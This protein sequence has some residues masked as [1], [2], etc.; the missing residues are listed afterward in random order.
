MVA[1]SLTGSLAYAGSPQLLA[2]PLEVAR[3]GDLHD[4]WAISLWRSGRGGLDIRKR[5]KYPPF[6]ISPEPFFSR[7]A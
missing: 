7:Q 1:Q 5:Y 6:L 3:A 2:G 4:S